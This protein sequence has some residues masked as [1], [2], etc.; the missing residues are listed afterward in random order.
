MIKI[1]VF[2]PPP[3][4]DNKNVDKL[5]VRLD[6]MTL[7]SKLNLLEHLANGRLFNLNPLLEHYVFNN[8]AAFCHIMANTTVRPYNTTD[9]P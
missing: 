8:F 7:D 6:K 9:R 3:Q 2:L 4:V 5:V 1:I